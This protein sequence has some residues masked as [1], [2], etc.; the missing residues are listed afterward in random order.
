MTIDQPHPV[1]NKCYQ[2]YI[3]KACSRNADGRAGGWAVLPSSQCIQRTEGC[4]VLSTSLRQTKCSCIVVTGSK[5]WQ[6]PIRTKTWAC[7]TLLFQI[8]RLP[9]TMYLLK[10][11]ASHYHF[12]VLISGLTLH[13]CQDVPRVLHSYL[14]PIVILSLPHQSQIT[15]RYES[16]FVF[17]WK[18]EEI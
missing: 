4:V 11:L 15:F 1:H 2:L 18:A 8:G 3:F 7:R 13:L 14:M 6:G 10:H 9:R 5:C 16:N 12:Y 17:C